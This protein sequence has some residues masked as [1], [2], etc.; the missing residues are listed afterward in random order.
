MNWLKDK[1]RTFLPYAI[2]KHWHRRR[3]YIRDLKNIVLFGW[4]APHKYQLI[5]VEPG[6]VQLFAGNARKMERLLGK[7]MYAD[8]VVAEGD[9][10]LTPSALAETPL[11][12][13][14]KARIGEDKS[15]EEVGEYE[16]VLERIRRDGSWDGCHNEQEVRDRYV[17]L[18]ALIDELKV[19]R[20]LKPRHQFE[21]GAFREAEGIHVAVSRT[22]ELLKL[23]NGNHRLAISQAIGL[24]VV[25]VAVIL[26]HPECISSGAWRRILDRSRTLARQHGFVPENPVAGAMTTDGRRRNFG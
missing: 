18:D 4:N 17:V 22:G 20:K 14:A 3:I 24:E 19:A 16:F 10:D 11:F 12:K 15:W 2:R 26:V 8:D 9:W 7:S 5:Y 6:S 25:P 21:E 23:G 1:I 13:R